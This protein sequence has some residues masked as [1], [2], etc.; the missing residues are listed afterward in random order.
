VGNIQTLPNDGHEGDIV[1]YINF[2]LS[3]LARL[4]IG[5]IDCYVIV[6]MSWFHL[7]G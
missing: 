3:S 4:P 7:I 1:R 5:I 6:I 2:S